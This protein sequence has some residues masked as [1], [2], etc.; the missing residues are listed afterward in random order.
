MSIRP[1]TGQILSRLTMITLA[2]TELDQL[3]PIYLV[4]NTP[5]YLYRNLRKASA[6]QRL[7]ETNIPMDLIDHI[8]FVDRSPERDLR[9]VVAAYASTIALTIQDSREVLRALQG[10]E[11]TNLEWVASILQ[12]WD[13]TRIGTEYTVVS[14]KPK[15]LKPYPTEDVSESTTRIELS[16]DCE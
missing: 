16:G 2:P 3:V 11:V 5:A 13:Q 10:L 6:V 15:I 1:F 12:L 4:A 14:D 8:L 7:A 9:D